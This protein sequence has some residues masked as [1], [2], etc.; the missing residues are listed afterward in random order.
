MI[1]T[2]L[3]TAAACPEPTPPPA[4]PR[5]D[6]ATCGT[7]SIAARGAG[8]RPGSSSARGRQAKGGADPE[9]GD[10]A[11]HERL[12]RAEAAARRRP[13]QHRDAEDAAQ[14]AD[15]VVVPEACPARRAARR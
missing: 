2:A 13:R 4:A 12:R 8:R 6:A 15:R 10:E 9:R 3:E 7:A 1:S 11:V 5:R 14:L